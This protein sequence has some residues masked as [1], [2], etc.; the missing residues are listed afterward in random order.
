MRLLVAGGGTGGHLFPGIAVAQ[1]LK[2][3]GHEVFWLGAR[4]GLEAERV[5]AEGF[6]LTLLSVSGAV[7]RSPADQAGA[8]L[9]VPLAVVRAMALIVRARIQGVLA[10]GGYASLPGALAAAALGVPLVLQEQNALPGLTTRTLAPWAEAVACG[11]A[12]ALVHFP[13]LPAR[14]TG[15]PVRPEFFRVPPP[16]ASGGVLVLGGSQ[17]SALLNRTIP[18]A[19]SMLADDGVRP[20]VVHQAG[21]RWADSVAAEYRQRAV[22]AQ[23]VPFLEHPASALAHA[24][25]VVARAGALTVSELAAARRAAI[26]IPFAA[27]AHG[28]QAANAA[29]LAGTGAADV[30]SE[31]EATPDRLASVLRHRLADPAALAGRGAAGA[32][33][34]RPQAAREVAALVVSCAGGAA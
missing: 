19:L 12:A 16:P 14:F 3:A 28:H 10:V 30:L 1:E 11:F 27:A 6:P 26:L 23:V 7:G 18:E 33:L 34:A 5:P 32:G 25:L 4:R 24:A 21:A 13:S 20:P 2:A 29:A 15:N 31:S 17:G 22:A 8:L 9:R